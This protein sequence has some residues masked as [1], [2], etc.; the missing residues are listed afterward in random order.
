MKEKMLGDNRIRL[1]L[2]F[3]AVSVLLI[4][5]KGLATGLD[6]QGGSII[7]IETERPLDVEEMDRVQIIMDERLRG[8]L[9]VRDV[10]V[11]ALGDQHVRIDVAGVSPEEL[12]DLIGK[13]GKL[14]VK[15]GNISAFTGDELDRVDPFTYDARSG[16]W[17]VPFTLSDGA[18]VKFRDASIASDFAIVYMYMDEGTL[19]SVTTSAE[20]EGIEGAIEDLNLSGEVNIEK[21][22]FTTTTTITLDN[23]LEEIGEKKDI[24]IDLLN[25][26]NIT[27]FSIERTGLVN[28]APLSASLQQELAAG[29]TVRSLILE[30]GA[31]EDG[32]KE[33]R[34]I[35]VIL[36]SG[37]LPIKVSVVSSSGISATLGEDFVKNAILAAVLAFGGVSAFIYLRYRKL[38]IVLPILVTSFSEIIIILG[39]AALI[40][41]NIDLPAIAGIIAAVGTGVDNQIVIIDEVMSG[42]KKSIRYRINSAFFIILCSYLTLIAA[43]ATL[44]F[45]GMAML[46][47]FAIT[48]IIGAT[49]GVFV[50]RP[51]YARIVEYLLTRKN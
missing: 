26:S 43:M 33:A 17:A 15:I 23:T 51:A 30:T 47:G 12:K 5:T 49:S 14:E 48:T 3:V 25:M 20:P 13:P 42:D 11:R 9:G 19:F 41:W 46:K 35:E 40:R 36:R 24:I 1:L 44:F 4:S 18:S 28:D 45:V 6:L 50:T 22:N 10:K 31:G 39:F 37:A 7:I 2:L 38:S 29:S 34:R 21:G 27:S 8:G 32:R 16:G